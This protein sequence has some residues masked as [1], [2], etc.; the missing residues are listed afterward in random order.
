MV[1]HRTVVAAMIVVAAAA[2]ITVAIETA[3]TPVEVCYR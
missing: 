2:V 3:V 1:D